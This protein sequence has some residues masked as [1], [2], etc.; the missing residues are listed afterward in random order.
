MIPRVELGAINSLLTTNPDVLPSVE[1]P[2]DEIATETP[3]PG[4]TPTPVPEPVLYVVEVGDSLS[5]IAEKFEVSM[6]DIMTANGFDNPHFIKA[7]QTLIIPVGGVANILPTTHVSTV[8]DET[9]IPINPPTPEGGVEA[10]PFEMLP[11]E[12]STL[13]PSPTAPP[14]D[15]INVRITNILG[16]GQL[17]D[18]MVIIFNQ[19]PGVNLSNWKLTGPNETRYQFPNLFLWPEGSVRIHTAPGTNTASDLYW[20]Q[21]QPRWLSGN[22]IFLLDTNDDVMSNYIIP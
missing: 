21:D 5:G 1:Q 3:M 20:G 7:G 8:P 12:T 19:G 4:M 18:E 11:D 2:L 16:Y 9:E 22:T 17:E 6:P 13:T 14:L 10:T 15:K